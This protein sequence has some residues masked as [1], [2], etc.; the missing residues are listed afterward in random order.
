M[1]VF[2]L[3]NA[4]MCRDIAKDECVTMSILFITDNVYWQYL[5]TFIYE[6]GL[7]EPNMEKCKKISELEL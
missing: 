2:N 4:G 7:K 1:M 3:Y 6:M 5:N